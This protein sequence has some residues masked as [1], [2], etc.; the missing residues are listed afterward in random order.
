MASLHPPRS[1]FARLAALLVALAVAASS[2]QVRPPDEPNDSFASPLDEPI[3]APY[4]HLDAFF[5]GVQALG[6]WETQHEWMMTA[7][8]KIYARSGWDSDEDLASLELV[9]RLS[10]I[11][12]WRVRD[13]YDELAAF[14]TERYDLDAGQADSLRQM[15]EKIDTRMMNRHFG[16]IASFGLDLVV[17]RLTGQPITAEKAQRWTR[18]TQ[19]VFEDALREM[20]AAAD[21][22]RAELRPEQ[23]EIFER[24]Y[25]AGLRRLDDA[26][27]QRR[28]WMAGEW[29]AADWGIEDDPIQVAGEQRLARLGHDSADA[30]AGAMALSESS[31]RAP[32]SSTDAPGADADARRP[33]EPDDAAARTA[34]AAA[35]RASDAAATVQRER[36]RLRPGAD[37]A[38]DP[39]A[40]FVEDYIRRYRLD[41]AQQQRA[42]LIYRDVKIRADRTRTRPRPRR[43]GPA[44][45]AT[46]EPTA[47]EQSKAS[48][49]AASAESTAP[50]A[51]GDRTPQ[52]EP[53]PPSA[54]AA[55]AASSQPATAPSPDP[56][57]SRPAPSTNRSETAS[58]PPPAEKTE[59]ERLFDELKRR[60]DRLPT[61]AQRRAAE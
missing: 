27:E 56:A 61:R 52:G 60:L 41:D 36:G 4:S 34:E 47:S 58:S 18:L 7:V 55:A 21:A 9:R 53:A 8:E 57:A 26:A 1:T 12:P 13:G 22:L 37:S 17:N 19:P 44:P 54:S 25:R 38:S 11:P 59:I 29:D 43:P 32:S 14:F 31:G 20:D 42:W 10:A 48:A 28:R 33:G 24:D 45:T 6:P 51:S 35:D 3:D 5:K 2:A 16:R 40:Q 49:A 30:S 39:W 23:R 15:V 46:S 50:T